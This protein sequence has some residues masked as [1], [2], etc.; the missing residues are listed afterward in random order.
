MTWGVYSD[1][2]NG[3]LCHGLYDTVEEAAA[4]AE[5]LSRRTGWFHY[6]CKPDELHGECDYGGE[7]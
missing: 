1:R 5:T 3:S 2:A 4:T 6:Y 7:E